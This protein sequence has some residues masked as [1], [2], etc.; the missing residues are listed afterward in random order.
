MQVKAEK[1]YSN[2]F[3]LLASYTLSKSINNCA[4][5]AQS[6][7][8]MTHNGAIPPFERQ[9]NK[10]IS[11]ADVPQV[12]SVAPIYQLPIGKGKRFLNR[13]GSADKVVGGWQLSTVV[14]ISSPTPFYSG[15]ANC[16]LSVQFAASC[17]PGILPEANPRAQDKAHFDP[18]KPLFNASAFE[19]SGRSNIQFR[20]G[21]GSRVTNLRG[22]GYHNED[23]GVMKVFK[24]TETVG[25]QVRR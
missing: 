4:E 12:L 16:N 15:V 14:R 20:S 3:Y 10:A 17:V 6:P 8:W 23:I 22:F 9:N 18:T 13:G 11:I 21:N 5:S 24:L 25:L 1:R 7:Q 2:G 19:G